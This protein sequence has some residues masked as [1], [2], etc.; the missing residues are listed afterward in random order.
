M[1]TFLLGVYVGTQ[2]KSLRTVLA[3]MLSC[4]MFCERFVDEIVN[5]RFPIMEYGCFFVTFACL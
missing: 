5:S 4:A 2:V 3:V 1:C